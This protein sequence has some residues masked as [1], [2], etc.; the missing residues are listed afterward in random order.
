MNFIDS[1]KFE[2]YLF[3][4]DKKEQNGGDIQGAK[5]PVIYDSPQRGE[6][7]IIKLNNEEEEPVLNGGAGFPLINFGILNK[8]NEKHNSRFKD[9]VVPMGLVLEK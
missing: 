9:L 3:R 5:R 7:S 2:N 1:S 8:N 6:S 4:W